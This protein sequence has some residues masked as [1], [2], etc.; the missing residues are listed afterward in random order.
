MERYPQ[1]RS[2]VS[3]SQREYPFGRA[4]GATQIFKQRARALPPMVQYVQSGETKYF[5]CSFSQNVAS[6]DDWTG[7]E[8]PCT[9]YIQSDGTTVGAYT[10][11]ALIPSAVGAGYGQ[12][13]GSK[14]HL[15]KIRVRGNLRGNAL[16]DQADPP[17]GANVRVVLVQ[18]LRPNGAQAQGEDVF[19]DLGSASQCNYAFLAMG[20][21][22]AGRF[23]ILA[24]EII[25]LDTL[26]A[27]TDG[28]STNSSVR[29]TKSF[30]FTK[31]FNNPIQVMLQA[32]SATP[33][34]ASLSS[35][36]IFLLA[37]SSLSTG[38]VAITGVARAY[39]EG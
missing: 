16:A 29:A 33:T 8:V 19:P 2:R 15:K 36:N 1:K 3:R 27:A 23:R 30:S 31:K 9:N 14:Y 25:D 7:T 13:V 21:G 6:A 18:D 17:A 39:Y 22:N 12:V 5:D 20:A 35:T 38:V 4:G 28:A 26:V 11:S 10:D 37:H 34:V 32:N 24:D